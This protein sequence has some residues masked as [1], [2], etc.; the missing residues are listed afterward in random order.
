MKDSTGGVGS[1]GVG[2]RN[3]FII[4]T[5]GCLDK[6]QDTLYA[7]NMPTELSFSIREIREARA[8]SQE[9]LARLIGVSVRTIARWESGVSRPS[10]LALEKLQRTVVEKK[11]GLPVHESRSDNA[12]L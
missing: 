3:A 6:C 7:L 1:G 9:A 12:S 11:G 8:L 2:R 10:P 5:L 4:G